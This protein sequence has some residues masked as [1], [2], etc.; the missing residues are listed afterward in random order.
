MRKKKPGLPRFTS[1][2]K[3]DNVDCVFIQVSCTMYI[4]L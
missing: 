4:C 2:G 1:C 3:A